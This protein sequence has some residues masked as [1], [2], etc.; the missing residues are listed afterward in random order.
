MNPPGMASGGTGVLIR[1]IFGAISSMRV[2]AE[3]VF[4]IERRA[5]GEVELV[6]SYAVEHTD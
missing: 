6:A 2:P 4:E 1:K 3:I 5:A